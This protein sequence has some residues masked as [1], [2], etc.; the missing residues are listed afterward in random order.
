M[1]LG[2]IGK[3]NAENVFIQTLFDPRQGEEL[4][5]SE[6]SGRID[7]NA[8]SNGKSGTI[9]AVANGN[10]IFADG[11]QQSDGVKV[12][13][14]NKPYSSY[15]FISLKD[16]ENKDI[17]SY[18]AYINADKEGSYRAEI[19]RNVYHKMQERGNAVYGG[20]V[21]ATVNRK[22]KN[23]EDK[24]SQPALD[25][26][27]KMSV[28]VDGNSAKTMRNRGEITSKALNGSI[29]LTNASISQGAFHVGSDG[30]AIFNGKS[31]DYNVEY[32][33]N[34]TKEMIGST[35]LNLATY[36]EY[37]GTKITEYKA[38]FGGTADK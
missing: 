23:F 22:T 15:G 25:G 20:N 38:V 1:E 2:L 32:S 11:K 34:D 26:K 36:S 10:E 19:L 16:S 8:L 31:G 17:H 5:M 18:F 3:T 12:I 37:D 9:E 24:W 33:S 13:F 7:L 27:V 14:E 35:R 28:Y 4:S 30:K 29:L 6:S 21:Y